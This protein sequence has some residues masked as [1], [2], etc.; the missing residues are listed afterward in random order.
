MINLPY[1]WPRRRC[2]AVGLAGR[3]GKARGHGQGGMA[4]WSTIEHS[5]G[6]YKW[7]SS[8]R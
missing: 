8:I 5:T 4:E 6:T 2:P 7:R 1:W 3:C